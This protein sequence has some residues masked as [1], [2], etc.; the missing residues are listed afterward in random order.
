MRQTDLHLD[1]VR[2]PWR[3]M[4]KAHHV[5]YICAW[6]KQNSRQRTR[7]C[8]FCTWCSAAGR[9]IWNMGWKRMEDVWMNFFLLRI[10]LEFDVVSWYLASVRTFRSRKTS[11]SQHTGISKP[12]GSQSDD[13]ILPLWSSYWGFES[14]K[15][16]HNHHH[17]GMHGF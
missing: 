13:C 14:V 3:G 16:H 4:W 6:G 12:M 17:E 8:N 10:I 1:H 7:W 5:L 11:F 9:I 2:A 15:K